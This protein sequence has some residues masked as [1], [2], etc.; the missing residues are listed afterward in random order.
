MRILRNALASGNLPHAY[1]FHGA[2][3][4]GRFTTALALAKALLCE[5]AAGDFCGRCSSCL[6]VDKGSHPDL[7]VVRPESRKGADH[8]E[9]DPENGSIHIERIRSLQRWIA[10]RAFEGGWKICILDGAE[11]MNREAS[12]ALLKT[13]EEPPPRS[14]LVLV[15]TSRNRLLPT[16]V[17]RCRAVHFAPIPAEELAEL[18]QARA[19]LSPERAL[20][21]ASLAEGSL[22][23]ALAM[24]T[25]W[26]DLERKEWLGKL[27]GILGGGDEAE[28]LDLADELRKSHRLGDLLDLYAVWLRD[29]LVC[30][31]GLPDRVANKDCLGEITETAPSAE[32]ET[33]IARVEAVRRARREIQGAMNLNTQ[34]LM[35]EML[36]NLSGNGG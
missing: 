22:G 11:K 24:D 21:V 16:I 17:S 20:L 9:E 15:A 35:E 1:L 12:N 7:L 8:W 10:P 18:L 3:G 6:R 33:W 36:L 29:H 30:R 13:L 23:K 26:L 32:P 27:G 5:E 34:L 4:R 31:I 14:L 25:E 19:G 28:L 2:E